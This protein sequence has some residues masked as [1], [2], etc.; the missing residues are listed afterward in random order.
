MQ[1]SRLAPRAI[2]LILLGLHVSPVALGQTRSFDVSGMVADSTGTGLP[3]ATVVV[4]NATD[5]VLVKFATTKADGAFTVR[6][7]PNGDFVL[8]VTFVG[9]DVLLKPFSVAGEPV[10]L[11]RL[12]LRESLAELG[13]LV[14]SADRIP[15]VIRK[16]TLEYNAAAFP[17]PVNANVEELLK[18]LPGVEVERDGTIRAQGE[19]VRQVLV[20]GKEFF[21]NDPTV[22]TRNLPASAVDRVQV[23][24]KMSDM[25]EFTGVADGEEA[26]T[27]NLAL[28]EDRR[29]GLFGNAGGGY[30]ADNRYDA[31]ASIN[32][33]NPRSQ[34]SFIGNLNNVN[35]Q[36]FSVGDYVR[37]LGGMQALVSE[38]GG[39]IRGSG[40]GVPLGTDLSDGFTTTTAGGLNLSREFNSKTSLRGSYFISRIDTRLDRERLVQ[41]LA[42]TATTSRSIEDGLQETLN[43]NHRLNLVLRHKFSDGHDLRVRSN[44]RLGGAT[45]DQYTGRETFAAD[46]LLRNSGFSDYRYDGDELA[47][48]ATA[49]WR[50]RLGAKGTTLVAEAGL[51]VGDT[52]YEGRLEALNQYYETGDPTAVEEF[53]QRQATDGATLR[54]NQKVSLAQPIGKTQLLEL[55]LER[56]EVLEDQDRAFYD[57]TPEGETLNEGLSS[58][59]ER[60]YT[61][62]R[63][64]A[65]MRSVNGGLSLSAGFQVQ[66]ARLEGEILNR[67]ADV[68]KQFLSVLP[69]A[70][71]AYEFKE[72]MRV[73]VRYQ[74][75]TREPS[76]RELQPF[77]DNSDPLNVYIGNPDLTPEYT[78]AVNAHYMLFDSFSFTNFFA[79]AQA[80]YTTNRIVRSRTVDEQLRQTITSVNGG[81]DW[82]VNG[83]VS[84]GTPVRPFGIKVDLSNRVFFNRGQEFVNNAANV[85]NTVSNSVDL[86]AE[87]RDKDR[88]DVS[89]GA[90]YAFNVNR[91]SLNREMDR[92]YLNRTYYSTLTLNVG[93]K[94]RV[95]SEFDYRLFDKAVFGSGGNV[96]L[97][98]AEVSRFVLR[99]KGEV[100]FVVFDLLDRNVGI[101]YTN[102]PGYVQEEQ[103]V[104]L[105]R[106][107][108]VKFVYHLSS[109]PMQGRGPGRGMRMEIHG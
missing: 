63:A 3:R 81:G 28:R 72:G 27:I 104:S 10:D 64:G 57:V 88:V 56:R 107:A 86:R 37:F 92:N 48:D 39:M 75:S 73:D 100:Q 1:S 82:R 79:F 38:G 87:N 30:G 58:A 43:L 59:F 19:E 69:R 74:T 68:S 29:V 47:G 13:E 84:Y 12:Q 90:R 2:F 51:D 55:N 16:D 34:T 41:Q 4:L 89:V 36:G 80:S 95:T 52:S 44:L 97:W 50:K 67:S 96:P 35:R 94:W 25:A 53:L 60:T 66:D 11:G 78:H 8:Q 99:Q 7:V 61:Y 85:T 108:L 5:S 46:A 76:M 54:H 9:Y 42:G 70:T 22:A 91:Y 31:A 23:F 109:S 62:G 20:D 103:I 40:G 15:M 93:S 83:S 102:A 18:R 45:L 21:G 77:V 98:R 105:G 65:T 106:Y 26:R 33:F 24:N 49:T 71:L 32:R 17:V 101:N 6:R 14:V